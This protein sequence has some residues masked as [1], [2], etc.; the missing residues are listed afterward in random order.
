MNIFFDFYLFFP[1]SVSDHDRSDELPH[2]SEDEA[3]DEIVDQRPSTSQN[4]GNER[5]E[6]DDRYVFRH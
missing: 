3:F 1:F 6:I 2:L 5:S 4:A